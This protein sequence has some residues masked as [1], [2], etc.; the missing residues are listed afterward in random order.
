MSP[1]PSVGVRRGAQ[2][3]TGAGRAAPGHGKKPGPG[4]QA[5]HLSWLGGDT[6]PTLPTEPNCVWSG[7][8]VTSGSELGALPGP[9]GFLTHF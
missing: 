6:V 7:L 5:A 9:A 1:H 2:H 4:H 3:P 8:M